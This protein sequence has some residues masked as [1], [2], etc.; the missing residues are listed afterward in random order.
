MQTRA[1]A[2]E[3]TIQP[4]MAHHFR[5]GQRKVEAKEIGTLSTGG[6]VAVDRHTDAD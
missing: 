2:L 4:R 6:L 1:N 3:L 5:C